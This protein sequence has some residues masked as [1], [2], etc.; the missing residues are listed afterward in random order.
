MTSGIEYGL[1]HDNK[2]VFVKQRSGVREKNDHIFYWVMGGKDSFFPYFLLHTL[3]HCRMMTLQF[4]LLVF[5]IST[6]AHAIPP[7]GQ[8]VFQ[9]TQGV[10]KV[11]IIGNYSEEKAWDTVVD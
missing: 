9:E 7:S 11:A 5:A 6:L 1:F 2:V 10:T 8:F 3:C 4:I